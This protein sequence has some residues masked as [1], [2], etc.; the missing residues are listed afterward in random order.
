MHTNKKV[1]T[2]TVGLLAAS[3]FVLSGCD[4]QTNTNGSL[5]AAA[6]TCSQQCGALRAS[7][8]ANLKTE[9][10]DLRR[11]FDQLNQQILDADSSQPLAPGT[12][13]ALTNM[14]AQLAAV[15]KA[16]QLAVNAPDV[17]FPVKLADATQLVGQL[18]DNLGSLREMAGNDLGLNLN[19]KGDAQSALNGQGATL[20]DLGQAALDLQAKAK[21][22]STQPNLSA[23]AKAELQA[24]QGRLSLLNGLVQDRVHPD[25]YVHSLLDVDADLQSNLEG[26]RGEVGD[27]T[28][29]LGAE[30]AATLNTNVFLD[31]TAKVEALL[32]GDAGATVPTVPAT[33]GLN[34]NVNATTKPADINVQGTVNTRLPAPSVP[35]KPSVPAP[36][37]NVNASTTP[38]TGGLNINASVTT[39][40]IN[41]STLAPSAPTAPSIPSVSVPSVAVPAVNI[42]VNAAAG[43]LLK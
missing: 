17:D 15:D 1:L 11:A 9:A 31:K 12:Q 25:A 18:G 21:D 8:Q 42:D 34:I 29:K 26:L 22:L 20:Q 41:T 7:T 32:K 35:V 3:M 4:M 43:G 13:A 14:P 40:S 39:P 23:D 6:P 27:V 37:V 16:V 30:A 33:S 2:A 5:T 36:T 10:T 19:L 28:A 24:L 38:A